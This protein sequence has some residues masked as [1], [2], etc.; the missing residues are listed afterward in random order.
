MEHWQELV[1][2]VIIGL[3]F[4]FFVA[5]LI[6]IVISFRDDNLKLTREDN[7]NDEIT[8]TTTTTTTEQVINDEKEEE[9]LLAR[10][11]TS[12]SFLGEEEDDWEGVESTELDDAFSAATAF[13]AAAASDRLSQKVSNDVQLE[14][15]GLY[16]IATEGPCTTPQ[17]SAL[18]ISA[19]AKWNTWQ[20]LGTMGQEEAMQRY[21]I[22]VSELYPTWTSGL[23]NRKDGDVNAS[24]SDGNSMMGPVFSTYVYEEE[25]DNEMRLEEMHVYAREGETENLLQQIDSGVSVNVKDSEGRTPLHWAVDRGHFDMVDLLLRKDAD[26][27]AKDNEGQTPLHYAAMCDREAVAEFLVKQNAKTD[28]KD[29]DGNSPCDLCD[30]KWSWMRP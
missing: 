6:S 18:K 2:S 17:P 5:K 16:K 12:D 10:T 21:I 7:N 29:N 13:V 4:S 8:T 19:R 3:I 20:R 28:I 11:T 1:Q 14:L 30:A 9:G 23:T 27:N 25:T 15:Y 24:S 22:I 26:V